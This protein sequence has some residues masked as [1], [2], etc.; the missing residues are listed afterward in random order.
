MILL[1]VHCSLDCILIY[2]DDKDDEET[3]T[4]VVRRRTM[5]GDWEWNAAADDEGKTKMM[6]RT[7]M[8]M[9]EG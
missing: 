8:R 3:M 5:D 4:I 9:R 6:M 7:M 1:K 2:D